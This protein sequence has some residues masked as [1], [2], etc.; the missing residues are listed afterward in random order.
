MNYKRV[1]TQIIQN[2]KQ[3]P[4]PE[5]KYGEW[6]HIVP[7]S[8][9]GSDDQNNLVRLT[10]R[11]HFVCHALLAEMYEEGTN[12]WYKMNHA[13]MMMKCSNE[14]QNRYFNSRLY[15]LKKKDF[16]KTQSFS[17]IGEKNSQYG[18]KKSKKHI[19]K[20]KKTWE[21]KRGPL[22][23]LEKAKIRSQK[24]RQKELEKYTTEE[25]TY[26]NK[27]RRDK[28]KN[29]F[30]IDLESNFKVKYLEFKNLLFKLYVEDKVSTIQIGDKFNTSSETIRLYLKFLKIK[31]R[32]RSKALKIYCKRNA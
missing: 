15:E 2:R 6:H 32:T 27:Y 24:Q 31:R 10:A 18:K 22:N 17:Q 4:L 8:L 13:F 9:N 19:K 26:I 1:Y 30:N 23:S 12:E 28:I 14:F 3:K 7:R 21:K 20:L 29:I 25:G 16:S 5:G 11:E